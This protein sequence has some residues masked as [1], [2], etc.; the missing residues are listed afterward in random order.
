M[1]KM[2]INY[3]YP[4]NNFFHSPISLNDSKWKLYKIS[5]SRN[6]Q[7]L[8]NNNI[9]KSY[10]KSTNFNLSKIK[11][12][13]SNSQIKPV[14]NKDIDYKVE[15][16]KLSLYSKINKNSSQLLSSL[17]KIKCLTQENLSLKQRLQNKDQ[18]ISDFQLL[19]QQFKQKFIKLDNI[20]QYLK[21]KLANKNES[22]NYQEISTE[23]NSKKDLL[24]CCNNIKNDIKRIEN[25]YNKKLKEKDEIIEKMNEELIYIHKEY[26]QLSGVIE[27]MN[28]FIMNSN[29]KELKNKINDLL[30]EKELLLKQNE[31]REK[32]IVD[33]QKRNEHCLNNDN[34][35]ENLNK[36]D[37]DELIMTFKNQENEYVKTINMLQSRI[38]DKDNEI[39]M[40]K[41]EYAKIMKKE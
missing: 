39:Q 7:K 13:T 1:K 21:N 15:D 10:D 19:F 23:F 30:K 28:V 20:N 34:E 38:I 17:E 11:E 5:N 33:L 14:L 2:S 9:N 4:K 3:K 35:I 40:I 6:N 32:R 8:F 27:K 29:Y 37:N 22:I 26:K 18:I 25:D 16:I 12:F 24:D 36:V 31:Q 41:E